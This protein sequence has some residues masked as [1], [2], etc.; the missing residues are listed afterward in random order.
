MS[1]SNPI[2][3]GVLLSGSGRT[4][5]NLCDS[6]ADGTLNAVVNIVV[7]S[8]PDAYG[9]ARAKNIGLPAVSIPRR[10][11]S[12][13][14]FDDAITDALAHADI[15][16]VCMAGFL[17]FWRIPPQFEGKV[18]NI[19]PALLPAF[20]G[21]GFYGQRVH[22][23]VIQAGSSETGCTVHFCDNQY[24]NGQIILQRRIEV[25]PDDTP[26]SLAERVFA[27]ECI[28]YPAAIQ[29]LADSG[30]GPFRNK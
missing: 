7:S 6:I 10:G 23:A 28:A 22:E 27:E 9:L 13:S 30:S 5:Q 12:A 21:K 11:L 24:D 8:R 29:F 14:D 1:S 17:S 20:G 2:R 18:I 19:H 26:G 25:S 4:L 15:D 3:L 16:L